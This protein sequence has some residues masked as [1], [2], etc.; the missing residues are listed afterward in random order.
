MSVSR[1]VVLTMSDEHPGMLLAD[2]DYFQ[3]RAQQCLRLAD[4]SRDPRAAV[5]LRS[6]AAAFERKARSLGG[7]PR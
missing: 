7:E 2:A 4:Q 1:A 5:T 6:L 3:K